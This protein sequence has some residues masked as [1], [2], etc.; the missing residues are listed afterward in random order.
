[1]LPRGFVPASLQAEA[2]MHHPRLAPRLLLREAANQPRMGN[3]SNNP[4]FLNSADK[5]TWAAGPMKQLGRRPSG[6]DPLQSPPSS[7]AEG[8][9]TAV[10]PVQQGTT[11]GEREK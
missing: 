9:R 5:H 2:Q 1:M 3:E 10:T 11:G 8:P 7:W 6:P 4:L